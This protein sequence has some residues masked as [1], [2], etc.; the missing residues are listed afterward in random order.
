MSHKNRLWKKIITAGLLSVMLSSGLEFPVYGAEKQEVQTEFPVSQIFN[1]K[2]ASNK[3]DETFEYQI[4]ALERGNP[5]PKGSTGGVYL[6]SMKGTENKKIGPVS[7]SHGGVYRYRAEQR[8][9]Q[10]KENYTYDK[11]IYNIEVYV[12]NRAEGLTAEMVILD[13]AGCKC[14]TM[15][16]ENKYVEPKVMLTGKPEISG[17]IKT[18]DTNSVEG[19]TVLMMMSF[20]VGFTILAA[21]RKKES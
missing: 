8:I 16:F 10:E 15:E 17:N 5:L 2:D 1:I 11:T 13:E 4:L 18:S 12:K 9:L 21:E 3:Q 19:Y 6:F 14:E 7:Y 20:A